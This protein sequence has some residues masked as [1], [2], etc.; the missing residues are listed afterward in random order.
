MKDE[1]Y[2]KYVVDYLIPENGVDKLSVTIESG[3]WRGW[4]FFV[5]GLVIGFSMR[6]FLLF[7]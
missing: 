3:H 7:K 4:V 6:Y 2:L 1:E 5:I